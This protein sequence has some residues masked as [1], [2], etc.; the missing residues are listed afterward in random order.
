MYNIYIPSKGRADICTTP[1]LFDDCILVVEPQ[2]AKSYQELHANVI[3]ME[4]NDMGIAYARNWIKQYSIAQ[5]EDYHWQIDDNIKS[6]KWRETDKNLPVPAINNLKQVETYVDQYDNIGAAGLKHALFAWTEKNE[7]D[8]NKQV[9]TCVL[10]NNNTNI[11]WK[12]G[13]I[14]DTDY[15]LQLLDAGYCTVI[16]NRLVMDKATT[17]SM[18]GGNTEISYG[19]DNRRIRAEGLQKA[20]PG[21]FKL[22]EQYGRVKVNP[23]RIWRTFDQRPGKPTEKLL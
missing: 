6:F 16:F 1:A 12:D 8:Y 23:S 2:D 18:K 14:E 3:V 11:W 5:N 22:S 10:F 21:V 15:S 20:W 13:L 9:Y 19:G 4:E 17:M 7:I